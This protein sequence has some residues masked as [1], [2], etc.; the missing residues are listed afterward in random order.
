MDGYLS[1]PIDR[2]LL[3]ASVEQNGNQPAS[4]ATLPV[5][6]GEVLERL[7]GD[8]ELL[9]EVVRLFLEDCPAQL[10]R[11][12]EAVNARDTA[13][14][15]STAH[16]LKGVAGSLAASTLFASARDLEQFGA[17]GNTDAALAAWG[18]LATDAEQVMETLKQWVTVHD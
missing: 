10:A 2:H 11:L 1:K 12:E 17:D 9:A 16:A 13:R 5:N 18:R 14:I 3:F 6:R 15:R 4:A 7:G 8:E